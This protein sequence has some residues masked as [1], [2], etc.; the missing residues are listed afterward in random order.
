[1]K[2]AIKKEILV[3]Y[4]FWLLLGLVIPFAGG[5][6][7]L[8][9]TTVPNATGAQRKKLTEAEKKMANLK[10]DADKVKTKPM[11]DAIKARTATLNDRKETVW[12]QAYD[13]QKFLLF[14]PEAMEKKYGFSERYE[15]GK[16]KRPSKFAEIVRINSDKKEKLKDYPEDRDQ[17]DE[18]KDKSKSKDMNI[19]HGDVVRN[20]P[21]GMV[22]RDRHNVEHFIF[23]TVD[24]QIYVGGTTPRKTVLRHKVIE[25][26]AIV[27]VFYQRGKY[28]GDLLTSQELDL[29]REHYRGQVIQDK[30][31]PEKSEFFPII[32]RVEPLTPFGTGVVRLGS[33]YYV[34]GT[35]PPKDSP[36][37]HYRAEPWPRGKD[38]SEDAWIAQENLWIQSEIYSRIRE[39]NEFVSK[40]QPI[41]FFGMRVISDRGSR[42]RKVA[43]AFSKAG[44]KVND[45]VVQVG[46]V[47]AKKQKG[48]PA[49]KVKE[50]AVTDSESFLRA[51]LERDS[52]DQCMISVL[53]GDSK[54]KVK[55]TLPEKKNMEVTFENPYW[56]VA[57]KLLNPT[58]IEAKFQNKLPRG[59]KLDFK[60]KAHT[61]D[62]LL[63]AADDLTMPKSVPNSINP[64][65]L[66]KNRKTAV[67]GEDSHTV[68]FE[69][70][71]NN[72]RRSAIFGLEQALTWETAAVRRIDGIYI[73]EV[74]LGIS[75][76]HRQFPD[77]L[78]A[79][80]K[81]QDYPDAAAPG[82]PPVGGVPPAGGV[83]AG[84][85]P[86]GGVPA[87][88]L[89]KPNQGAGD[90]GNKGVFENFV[91][92]TENGQ[93]RERYTGDSSRQSRKIPVA[94]VL[95]VEQS[96]VDRVQTAFNNSKLRFL[97]TQVIGFHHNGSL[98]P[99][100]ISK[101]A[102]EPVKGFD[103][104]KGIGV[105]QPPQ[106]GNEPQA[107]GG[108]DELEANFELVIYGTVTIYERNPQRVMPPADLK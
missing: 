37:L 41:E 73:S 61:S 50:K 85:V 88:G 97:P 103:P 57:M 81:P 63:I 1:M 16:L 66:S 106:G 71:P 54:V 78:Q 45:I 42:I 100:I 75:Q 105:F 76:C 104:M 15:D 77:K 64:K 27:T 87:G 92:K 34:E 6:F 33:W 69:E 47:P 48:K 98:R 36:F 31:T 68:L 40:F 14:W 55:V 49:V 35:D 93:I 10:K 95:T 70:L 62:D 18:N 74:G 72:P 32:S 22:V 53:R 4:K 58:T 84:G 65:G 90:G 56:E 43:G 52:G 21:D 20:F 38:F 83:P 8:L 30:L 79:Y 102:K 94:I 39:A 86:A 82:A 80:K 96:Q 9:M 17:Y 108:G 44:L 28:F 2:I 13:E 25:Q 29:Y 67:E 12:Q 11:I 7:F 101:D 23:D 99:T 26:K 46:D 107:G 51:L 60:L 59:Q 89:P 19:L 5:A 91:T 3:K 24:M